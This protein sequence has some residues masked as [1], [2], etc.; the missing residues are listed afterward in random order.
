MERRGEGEAQHSK[1]PGHATSSIFS[2]LEGGKL[3]F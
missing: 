3:A 2:V 1:I